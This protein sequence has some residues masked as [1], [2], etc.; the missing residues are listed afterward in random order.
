[1]NVPAGNNKI[2]FKFEPKTFK[3]GEQ[4][5]L[6]SSVILL[7]LILGVAYKEFK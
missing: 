7:L 5:S 1:M 6:A 4:I 2:E 3:T